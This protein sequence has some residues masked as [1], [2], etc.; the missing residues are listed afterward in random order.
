MS[1]KG[2][3]VTVV[4]VGGVFVY[5]IAR[6]TIEEALWRRDERRA[7]AYLA[8]VVPPPPP[9]E[10]HADPCHCDLCT[11]EV[12]FTDWIEEKYAEMIFGSTVRDVH[13]LD[14]Y[15]AE[16]WEPVS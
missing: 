7:E 16:D 8:A 12:S 14:V 3:V 6:S 5:W 13:E 10:S 4:L 15:W 9:E 11:G 2:G 1:G